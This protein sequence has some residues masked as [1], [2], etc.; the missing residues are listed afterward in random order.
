MK[1]K[2]AQIIIIAFIVVIACVMLF[3]CGSEP[4]KA[5]ENIT[6]RFI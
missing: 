4:T 6:G 1:H 2:I 5:E 3:A